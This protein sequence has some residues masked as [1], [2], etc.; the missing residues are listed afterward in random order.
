MLT[1]VTEQ[2]KVEAQLR[3][4]QPLEAVGQMT[5]GIAH[6]FN[7]LLT[8][9][10]GNAEMMEETEDQ[11]MRSLAEMARKAAERGAELTSRLLAFSRQQP[12]DPKAI[13]INALISKMEG[14]MRRAI[15]GQLEIKTVLDDNLWRVFADPSQLE[16][17]LLDLAINARDA[18]PS[19]GR[20][21]IE[22]SN[23]CL[24]D[25][26]VAD[27]TSF[28][29]G[30][31]LLVTIPI[32]ALE[33]TRIR[34]LT[35]SNRSSPPRRLAKA[36]ASVSAWSTASSSSRADTSGSIPSLV[37]ERPSRSI[38]QGRPP[39]SR[40]PNRKSAMD[41]CPVAAKG[42]CWSRTMRWY[43]TWL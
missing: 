20:L 42:I 34:W 27:E 19:G 10:I 4:S 5:G 30:D 39:T 38:F 41:R 26:A 21:T 7:N 14:L 9:I 37:W 15:G 43:G 32:P 11:V 18:M 33:W 8:V 24:D 17:A 2:R 1:D 6:D 13:D 25:A 23:I 3:Q 36:A 40:W 28:A 35:P 12:L 31:Y 22:T 16:N 29:R